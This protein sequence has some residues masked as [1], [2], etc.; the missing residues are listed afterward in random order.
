MASGRAPSTSQFPR[1][2]GCRWLVVHGPPSATAPAARTAPRSPCSPARPP[3]AL[4]G[5]LPGIPVLVTR[6]QLLARFWSRFRWAVVRDTSSGLAIQN[7]RGPVP[8]RRPHKPFG[9]PLKTSHVRGCRL[10]CPARPRQGLVSVLIGAV[11]ACGVPEALPS[12]RHEGTGTSQHACVQH[13]DR[14]P[15]SRCL[16]RLNPSDPGTGLQT[17]MEQV[18]GRSESGSDRCRC[19]QF[20]CRQQKGE[21]RLLGTRAAR[22]LAPSSSASAPPPGAVQAGV[23]L[24]IQTVFNEILSY[25]KVT[26]CTMDSSSVFSSNTL[27]PSTRPSIKNTRECLQ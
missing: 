13:P 10:L 9:A 23:S 18:E 7:R 1:L 22:G 26:G 6:R 17:K 11:S 12:R 15:A 5:A 8:G 3:F 16:P 25:T 14:L 27:H 24:V 20:Q 19:F 4:P 2:S 21:R